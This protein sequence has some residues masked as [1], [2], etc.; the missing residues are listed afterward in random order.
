DS[1]VAPSEIYGGTSNLFSTTLERFGI[2]VIYVD[3]NA[4]EAEIAA[5]FKPNTKALSGDIIANP[6]MSVLD[7]EKF[8]R[9]AHG[10]GVPLIVDSAFATPVLCKPIE[11]GADIVLHSASKYMDGHAVQV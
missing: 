9:I 2:E 1:F 7:V 3:Q 10:Q 6:A 8:A 11:Y 5:A 4:S